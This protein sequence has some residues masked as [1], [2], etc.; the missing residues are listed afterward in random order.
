VQNWNPLPGKLGA[1]KSL[2]MKTP[3]VDREAR[4]VQRLRYFDQLP[5]TSALSQLPRHEQYG[6][7]PF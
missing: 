2:R 7:W 4:T 6:N 3:D 1:P 5:F